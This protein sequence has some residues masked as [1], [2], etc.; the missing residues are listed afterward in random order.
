MQGQ[1]KRV[2]VQR[3]YLQ[4]TSPDD[5][6]PAGTRVENVRL[7]RVFQCTPAFFRFLYREVG[8][9]YHWVDRLAWTDDEIRAHVDRDAISLWVMYHGGAPA[10]YFELE[11]HDDGSTEIAYFGLLPEFIG[12]GLGK[13]LLSEAAAQAWADKPTRVW[14][15][16]CTLDGPAALPNYLTRGFRPFKQEVYETTIDPG[17]ELRPAAF[18]SLQ[19]H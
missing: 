12:L 11:R 18:G 14:L 7:D 6:R 13:Y 16:T 4:L 17:E 15:H 19:Q 3:T 1:P 9:H 5:L 10:G 2:E 8:R